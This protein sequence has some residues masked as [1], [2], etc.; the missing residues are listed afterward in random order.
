MLCSTHLTVALQTRYIICLTFQRHTH[1]IWKES[2]VT[3]Y[4]TRLAEMIGGIPPISAGVAG[5]GNLLFLSTHQKTAF[6]Y[7]RDTLQ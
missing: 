3:Q 5:I 4:S 2:E 1:Q 7:S 6:E